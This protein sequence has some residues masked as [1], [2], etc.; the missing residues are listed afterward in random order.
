M[1]VKEDRDLIRFEAFRDTNECLRG[2]GIEYWLD[3]GSLL[4]VV[5]EGKL[6]EDDIDFGAVMTDKHEQIAEWM[7]RL[8]F[9]V[10]Y[11]Y[12]TPEHGYQHSFKRNDV[13]V[14]IFYFYKKSDGG[15]W[16][17]SWWKKH[18]LIVSDFKQIFLPT[19]SYEFNNVWTFLP[20]EPESVLAA[21]YGDWR[22]PNHNWRWYRDPLCIR[23]D[24][25]PPL[26]EMEVSEHGI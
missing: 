24:T 14:D 22:T 4:G 26:K 23:P 8:G 12:G 6:F 5:R 17:G 20:R 21:R 18:H 1:S 19:Q 15:W 7:S 13:K 11:F 3:C 9:R 2:L 25:L 10:Y 16:Q